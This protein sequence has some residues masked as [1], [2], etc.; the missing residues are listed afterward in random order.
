MASDPSTSDPKLVSDLGERG[1]VERITERIGR[2]PEGETWAGDDAAV[3]YPPGHRL[4]LTTDFIVEG[5]DFTLETFP[6]DAI[7]WKSFAINVSDI[8]AMGGIPE[9]ALASM[10]LRPDMTVELVDGILE[11]MLRAAEKWSTSLVGGDISRGNE[12]MVSVSL[13]G[14]LSTEHGVYRSEAAVGDAICVTGSLGGAAA[15]LRELQRTGLT[16]T[17]SDAVRRQL[18]PEARVQEGQKVAQ[19]GATSMIDLSDGLAVDLGHLTKASNVGCEVDL[20]ALPL[21]QS[22]KASNDRDDALELALTGGEDFELLF[23][24]PDSALRAATEALAELG[25]DLTRIGTIT[26]GESR[27]GSLS[28]DEWKARGWDHLATR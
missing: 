22:L 5:V 1:L 24:M 23:T 19:A 18:Y 20:D 13:V 10:S 14:S 7:G 28:L 17:P 6:P 27:L 11:G 26:K 12:I 16:S 9:F 15:G 21:H 4:L 8:A 3:L 25:T 2:S